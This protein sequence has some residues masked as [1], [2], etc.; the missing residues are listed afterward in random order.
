MTTS[1]GRTKKL[2][3]SLECLVR[4]FMLTNF[5]SVMKFLQLFDNLREFAIVLDPQPHAAESIISA[6]QAGD[7][8]KIEDPSGEQTNYM[9]HD[10]GMI[11]HLEF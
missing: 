9:Q 2:L 1:V 6:R 3:Q 11:V 7:S 4:S 10:A 5:P 8:L